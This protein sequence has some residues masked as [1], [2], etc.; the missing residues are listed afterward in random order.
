M[1]LE[2]L[3][4]LDAIERYGTISAAAEHLHITQ[5]SLSR[6]IKRLEA[7]LGQQLF[8]RTKNSVRFNDAGR[9][10]LEHAHAM[11]AEE[12]RL[13]DDFDELARRQRTLKVFSVAPAPTWR[14]S[15]LVVERFPGV[16]LDPELVSIRQAQ[17]ALVNQDADFSITLRP[18]QLPGMTSVAIMTEDLALSAP[19]SS[20]FAQRDTV[21]FADL[22]GEPFLVFEQIGFWMDAC[23]DKL[24]HSQVIVQKDRMVFMQLVQSSD[25][26]CFTT[27]APENASVAANRVRV[28]IVD[29]EAHATFFLNART[30]APQ[31]VAR[32]MDWVRG[33]V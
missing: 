13:R 17:A 5:P 6:S 15:A 24:P 3:R 14:L 11:L 28:P 16:I 2:Q 31:Q 10:A 7:D 21:S 4:Q 30:D 32:I 1:E 29:A 12:R 22:D 33:Q 20:P 9:V 19:A 18:L 27:D 26:L 25:L 23:R 8:D